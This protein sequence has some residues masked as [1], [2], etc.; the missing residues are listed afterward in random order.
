MIFYQGLK[1][2][3][4]EFQTLIYSSRSLQDG[5]CAMLLRS[6]LIL[7]LTLGLLGCS[8]EKERGQYRD[9]ERPRSGEVP[10]PVKSD[11][12]KEDNSDKK[13]DKS[14]KSDP[15]KNDKSD[16]EKSKN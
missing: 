13:E 15:P 11:K 6:W 8:N 2:I 16:Q 3:L 10:K 7:I 5:V 12:A 14:G 4:D 1:L 9:K